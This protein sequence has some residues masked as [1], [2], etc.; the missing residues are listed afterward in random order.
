M[1]YYNTSVN[2]YIRKRK[3]HN[4]GFKYNNENNSSYGV[5]EDFKTLIST[6]N[7]NEFNVTNRIHYNKFKYARII[8]K[9][10]KIFVW[11]QTNHRNSG[12]PTIQ[13]FEKHTITNK[14]SYMSDKFNICCDYHHL[15][16]GKN[17]T[18]LYGTLFNFK[19]IKYFNI[20][21]IYSF[22]NVLTNNKNWEEKYSFI[23]DLFSNYIKQIGYNNKDIILLNPLT[24]S[25]PHDINEMKNKVP[26]DIYCVQYLSSRSDKVFYKLEQRKNIKDVD[27]NK[28][29]Y[30]HKYIKNNQKTSYNKNDIISSTSFMVKSGIQHDDYDIYDIKTNEYIGKSHIPDC[31][32]SSFMNSI[33]RNIRENENLDLLEESDD[34]EE[35]QNTNIDKFIKLNKEEILSMSFDNR[36]MLWKPCI[37]KNSV[38]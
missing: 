7:Y 10:K 18:V 20:E 34:E 5:L 36:F 25:L 30:G 27:M 14:I 33:F 2:K 35:F 12:M 1:S 23:N 8:P 38:M 31:K 19:N 3:C 22:K 21:D 28:E 13:Y 6:N 37:T 4:K 11:F 16:C 26:Y 17:G 9:G 32:T 15:S 24:H 29:D